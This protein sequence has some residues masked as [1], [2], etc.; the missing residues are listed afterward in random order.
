MPDASSDD[1][2]EAAVGLRFE[3]VPGRMGP[4]LLVVISFVSVWVIVYGHARPP[5]PAQVGAKAT[6]RRSASAWQKCRAQGQRSGMRRV[7][8]PE[9]LTSRPGTAK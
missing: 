3:R 2:A 6:A 9:R 4:G 5:A 1:C 8:R 7:G